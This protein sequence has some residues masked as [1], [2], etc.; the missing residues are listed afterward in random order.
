MAASAVC[1]PACLPKLNY[2][3]KGAACE[4]AIIDHHDFCLCLV[5]IARWPTLSDGALKNTTPVAISPVG[6][7]P[8]L[9]TIVLQR[10]RLRIRRVLLI[11]V[12][13]HPLAGMPP[14][15]RSL[16]THSFH[17]PSQAPLSPPGSLVDVAMISADAVPGSEGCL[18]ARD[19]PLRADSTQH[20]SSRRK[21]VQPN[22][23][24]LPHPPGS[25]LP[26]V[27]NH[28]LK[29]RKTKRMHRNP[30]TRPWPRPRDAGIA[31]PLYAVCAPPPTFSR[32]ALSQ[33]A[34]P[35]PR[36]TPPRASIRLLPRPKTI[37]RPVQ[38]GY[39]IAMGPCCRREA[40]PAN[41]RARQGC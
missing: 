36:G 30:Q 24:R 23:S 18:L 20:N 2:S 15:P 19:P 34:P 17:I 4:T 40:S 38:A 12:A 11:V 9:G 10:C 3:S 26:S 13:A 33:P 39:S 14:S 32:K 6:A 41:R 16:V 35:P 31:K 27:L 8:P 22:H 1:T 25:Q 28:S 7:K 5:L 21:Q 37:A 29:T